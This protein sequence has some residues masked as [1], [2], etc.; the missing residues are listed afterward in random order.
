[1]RLKKMAENVR[2][3]A[4]QQRNTGGKA[5]YKDTGVPSV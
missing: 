4:V 2:N 3:A 5:A 1:M